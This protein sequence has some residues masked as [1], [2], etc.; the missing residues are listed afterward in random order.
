[1]AEPKPFKTKDEINE[2]IAKAISSNSG[3]FSIDQALDGVGVCFL[4]VGD[5]TNRDSILALQQYI[6]DT[7]PALDLRFNDREKDI[8]KAFNEYF[9]E[10]INTGLNQEL[11]I[12]KIEAKKQK[13]IKKI[14]FGKLF[15]YSTISPDIEKEEDNNKFCIF[16]HYLIKSPPSDEPEWRQSRDIA[17]KL[18]MAVGG[19]DYL[20]KKSLMNN[21]F[22]TLEG[23]ALHGM[24]GTTSILPC[25]GIV[26]G[27]IWEELY[28]LDHR[29][30][31]K[32]R[33]IPIGTWKK[34]FSGRGNAKKKDISEL[35]DLVGFKK[36]SSDDE[37]DAIAMA[38]VAAS[39]S[40]ALKDT[41]GRI[42]P[43][44]KADNIEK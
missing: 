4:Y 24:A 6:F 34:H 37:N 13:T 27:S 11:S 20:F 22:V 41:A 1:M 23:M 44:R 14:Y 42:R 35:L 26:Y 5:K 43:F 12:D 32:V 38:I 33:E 16:I 29:I 18:S 28:N 9:G 19:Y 39:N 36:R 15:W 10:F 25:L 3:S 40:E 8:K 7:I 2:L 21:Y 17:K 30:Y 31:E